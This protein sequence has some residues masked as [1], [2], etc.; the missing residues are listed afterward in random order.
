MSR[1]STAALEWRKLVVNSLLTTVHANGSYTQT[2]SKTCQSATG[3]FHA[4]SLQANLERLDPLLG[5]LRFLISF[6]L[7]FLVGRL[8]LTR[9][10][11]LGCR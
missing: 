1:P 3:P 11:S 9:A 4:L 6:D 7:R 8:D 10:L 5:Q 2:F